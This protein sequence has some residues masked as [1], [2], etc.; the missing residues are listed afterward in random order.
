MRTGGDFLLEEIAWF[1]GG[2]FAQIDPVPLE[3]ADIRV[4]L[5]AARM[6]WTAIEPAIFGTLFERGLD[7]AKRSQLGAHYTDPDSIMRIVR[8]TVETEDRRCKHA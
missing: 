5:D 4:L 1:N 6:D 2:L 7:P 3:S 8:A